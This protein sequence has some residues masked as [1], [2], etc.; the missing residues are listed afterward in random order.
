MPRQLSRVRRRKQKIYK[1]V[2]KVKV[3]EYRKK[4]RAL[5][6]DKD[7]AIRRRWGEQIRVCE[8]GSQVKK[9]S[10]TDHLKTRKHQEWDTQDL[11]CFLDFEPY[12]LD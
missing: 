7:Q 3:N 11:D 8:C 5:N 12:E 2:H 10:W 6:R 1:R 4:W 9:K